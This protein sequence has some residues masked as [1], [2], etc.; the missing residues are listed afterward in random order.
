MIRSFSLSG[1]FLVRFPNSVEMIA[2][3][4]TLSLI[5]SGFVHLKI[6]KTQLSFTFFQLKA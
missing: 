2:R 6:E 5:F 3:F 4:L 1:T